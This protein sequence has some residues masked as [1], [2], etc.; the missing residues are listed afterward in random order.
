M[1]LMNKKVFALI[2]ARKGSKGLPGKN[3]RKVG[4]S[5]LVELAV[6]AAQ[7]VSEIDQVFISSDCNEVLS[8]GKNMGVTCVERPSHLASDEA[9]ASDVVGHFI[10]TLGEADISE[11]PFIVYLQPTSPLRTASHI[12]QALKS[13]E[14]KK[15]NSLISV[16][17]LDGSPFKSFTLNAQGTLSSLFDEKLSN[18][19]RQMLPMA[20]LPNGSIYIFKVSDFQRKKGFP[21]NGS[22]PFVMSAEES[23]DIDS[24]EDLRT[25]EEIWVKKYGRV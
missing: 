3:L 23:L 13:L 25:A 11:D 15:G 6:R 2:P 21:N 5:N 14:Q 17:E 20:Y 10:S 24:E 12:L 16:R 4:S 19:S 7:G 8:I 18:E 1:P 22:I 9:R